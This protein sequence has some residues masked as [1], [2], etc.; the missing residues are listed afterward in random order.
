M[1]SLGLNTVSDAFGQALKRQGCSAAS[2]SVCISAESRHPMQRLP[3]MSAPC[4]IARVLPDAF[5]LAR[6]ATSFRSKNTSYS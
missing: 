4:L 1:S 3:L 2:A 5:C 6:F